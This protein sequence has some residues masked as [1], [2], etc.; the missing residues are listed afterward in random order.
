MWR[1]TFVIFLFL[2]SSCDSFSWKSPENKVSDLEEVLEVSKASFHE[3]DT[4][5]IKDSYHEINKNIEEL[6]N[7]N[8]ND[9]LRFFADYKILKEALKEF[10]KARPVL[11][12]ELDFCKLQLI[13][14]KSDIAN[15]YLDEKEFERN[16]AIEKKAV[17]RVSKKTEVYHSGF[18][19]FKAKFSKSNSEFNSLIDSLKHK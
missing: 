14:L 10:I 19:K 15:G 11:G 12:K 7:I 9:S 4:I 18:L 5:W 8:I 3:I 6:K 2:L 13:N 17:N 1:L 16:F